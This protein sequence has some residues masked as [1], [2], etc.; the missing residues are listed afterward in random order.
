[1]PETVKRL[2]RE[3]QQQTA[4]AA[5]HRERGRSMITAA[6]VDDP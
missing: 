5:P 1:M 4:N 3:E 6:L 2:I